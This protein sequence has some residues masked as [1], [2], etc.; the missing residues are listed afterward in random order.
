MGIWF[1][2]CKGLA[3]HRFVTRRSISYVHRSI[4]FIMFIHLICSSLPSHPTPPRPESWIVPRIIVVVPAGQALHSRAPVSSWYKPELHN[5]VCKE[6]KTFKINNVCR[7]SIVVGCVLIFGKITNSLF[8][9]Y[10]LCFFMFLAIFKFTTGLLHSEGCKFLPCFG[11]KK[12]ARNRPRITLPQRLQAH[13]T[14]DNQFPRAC[15]TWRALFNG[16][17][18]LRSTRRTSVARHGAC[19][20]LLLP[21]RTWFTNVGRSSI[22]ESLTFS[23][24]SKC[25]VQTWC[26]SSRV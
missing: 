8:L 12:K 11:G 22:H 24:I 1:L 25:T 26:K 13:A 5:Q 17:H 6:F 21:S 4:H 7:L 9:L 15:R 2:D 19:T 18:G 16:F 14:Q 23:E 20:K 3:L 10:V